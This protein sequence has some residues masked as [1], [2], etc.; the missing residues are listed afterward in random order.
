MEV[1]SPCKMCSSSSTHFSSATSQSPSPRVFL[2]S[3]SRWPSSSLVC[4]GDAPLLAFFFLSFSSCPCFSLTKNPKNPLDLLGNSFMA[5]YIIPFFFLSPI[6][7]SKSNPQNF[8]LPLKPFKESPIFLK[9][10]WL[11]SLQKHE[12]Y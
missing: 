8:K 6:F 10:Q 11:V 4:C 1:S 5:A 2:C 9:L 3:L 7:P 12:I